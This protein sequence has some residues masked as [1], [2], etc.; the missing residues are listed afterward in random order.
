MNC[1]PVCVTWPL[2][3]Q[4]DGVWWMI[5]E[6]GEIPQDR[7]PVLT[8]LMVR[9]DTNVIEIWRYT[10]PSWYSTT[11][12]WESVTTEIGRI[13]PKRF[14][15]TIPYKCSTTLPKISLFVFKLKLPIQF[16]K[17]STRMLAQSSIKPLLYLK[18]VFRNPTIVDQVV[19]PEQR[20][21]II[22]G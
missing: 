13:G 2:K 16:V 11:L 6:R 14:V 17:K 9:D 20:G 10:F 19:S 1:Y 18:W 4:K 5:F 7:D 22:I 3:H 21:Q 8:D 12:K 15:I